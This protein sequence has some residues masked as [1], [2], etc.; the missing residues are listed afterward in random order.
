MPNDEPKGATDLLGIAPVARVAERVADSVVSAAEVSLGLVCKPALE[1]VGLALRDRV[2]A[3]RQKN[4]E[5][6]LMKAKPG[7]DAAA[8]DGRHGPMRLLMHAIEAATWVEDDD[9]QRMWA[10]LLASSCT[11]DGS[12]ESNWIFIGLL[13][14]L[15]TVQA[16]LLAYACKMA[17]KQVLANGLIQAASQVELELNDLKNVAG[18]SDLHQLDRELDHLRTLGLIDGGFQAFGPYIEAPPKAHFSPTA[19]GLHMFGQRPYFAEH[20]PAGEGREGHHRLEG[21]GQ[22]LD[23]SRHLLGLKES[24]PHVPFFEHRD[25]RTCRHESRSDSQSER[26]FDDR[27]LTIDAGM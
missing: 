4:Y 8:H 9:V 15:T 3:W 25:V 14:Q 27:Q 11:H 1:E 10:G 16:K 12:D 22:V 7:L 19:L 23:H 2:S 20:T 13:R 5:N 18:C 26:P 21:V 24:L 6:T 17:E